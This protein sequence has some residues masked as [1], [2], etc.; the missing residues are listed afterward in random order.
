[1]IHHDTDLTDLK[2]IRDGEGRI[3]VVHTTQEHPFWESGEGAWTAPG[4]CSQVTCCHHRP[5]I[6]HG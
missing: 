6:P 1:M 5:A 4:N 3:S 2:K